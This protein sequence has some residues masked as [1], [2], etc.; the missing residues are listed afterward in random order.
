VTVTVNN[1]DEVA[2]TMTGP[3]GATGS[4]STKSVDENSTAVHTFTASEAVTWSL[5]GGADQARFSINSS[6]ALSFI[7]APDF[8][9]PTDSD[10]NNTYV[11]QVR[12]VDAAG[13]AS[14]QTVT[15]TVDNLDEVAPTITGPSGATGSTSTKSVD[16]NSTA[17]HAFTASESVTWSLVGGDDQARFSINSS[18]VL[19]FNAAP[20]FE[21]PTDGDANNTYVVQLRA[22]DAAGNASLQ[23]ATVTITDL[24][25]VPPL[26]TGPG[27]ATGDTSRTA[28]EENT[29]AVHTFAANEAITWSIAGGAEAERFVLSADGAL[30]FVTAPDFERPADSD[31]DNVY[32]VQLRGVDAAGNST[33]QTL[34]V[35]VADRGES[36]P[37]PPASPPPAPIGTGPAP[38]EPASVL[39]FDTS[40]LSRSVDRPPAAQTDINGTTVQV[41]DPSNYVMTAVRQARELSQAPSNARAATG[42]EA[43]QAPTVGAG[44]GIDPSLHV[45][46]AVAGVLRESQGLYTPPPDSFMRPTLA[47]EPGL[48][49]DNPLPQDLPPAA[50]RAASAAEARPAAETA[51]PAGPS[52]PAAAQEAGT[53]V[54]RLGFSDQLR[55]A[56]E[57]RKPAHDLTRRAAGQATAPAAPQDMPA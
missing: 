33:V 4:T 44:L 7:A 54:A 52:A 16:E 13:N 48:G 10:S 31:G 35:T 45:L 29:T 28:I 55:Q 53:P 17:V 5:V 50:P 3:S 40:L 18:G 34:T 1:L 11:V 15:V 27:G 37:L 21:A 36:L 32:Q 49:E 24:D 41:V 14:L 51:T 22:V 9:A 38:S 47:A 46:P 56:A 6:G 23:T 8:E 43:G 25:E 42:P 2:P 39:I 30:S 19:S 26:L 12:A 57:A 20:D